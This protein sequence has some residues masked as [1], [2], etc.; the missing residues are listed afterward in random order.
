MSRLIQEL[1]PVARRATRKIWNDPRVDLHIERR[2]LGWV[3]A[4]KHQTD[5]SVRSYIT[6]KAANEAR[7]LRALTPSDFERTLEKWEA[8]AYQVY[9]PIDLLEDQTDTQPTGQL[10]PRQQRF[11]AGPRNFS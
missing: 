5:L 8:F 9:R 2:L 10:G 11:A 7:R 6:R 4:W 1:A 3:L